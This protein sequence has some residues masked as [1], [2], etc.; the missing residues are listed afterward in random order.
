M[1]TL[2]SLGISVEDFQSYSSTHEFWVGIYSEGQ[3]TTTYDLTIGH[4]QLFTPQLF[5]GK[6]CN[7]NYNS[8]RVKGHAVKSLAGSAADFV[9]RDIARTIYPGNVRTTVTMVAQLYVVDGVNTELIFKISFWERSYEIQVDNYN[10]QISDGD[11]KFDIEVRNWP[12]ESVGNELEIWAS[13]TSPELSHLMEY[14]N[15]DDND[16]T[17]NR[18]D[19]FLNDGYDT[20]VALKLAQFAMIDKEARP[21]ATY[22]QADKHLHFFLPYFEKS[23]V[24]DPVFSI[25]SKR[26]SEKTIT[27]TSSPV[28]LILA[29]VFIVIVVIIFAVLVGLKY[30]KHIVPKVRVMFHKQ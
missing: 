17:I 7:S 20:T 3:S 24:Y 2:G 30:K 25:Q 23:A 16:G 19:T 18:V 27:N 29:V 5:Y 14:K 28:G 11:V 13:F 6:P 10:V 15:V 21:I 12:F 1:D 9:W 26:L 22:L 4:D 8:R